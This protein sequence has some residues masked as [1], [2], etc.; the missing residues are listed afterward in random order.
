MQKNVNKQTFTLDVALQ[1]YTFYVYLEYCKQARNR[2]FHPLEYAIYQ[3][4]NP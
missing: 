1:L 3:T 4:L 2:Q